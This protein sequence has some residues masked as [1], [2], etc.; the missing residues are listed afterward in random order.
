MLGIHKTPEGPKAGK[1]GIKVDQKHKKM[2]RRGHKRGQLFESK[3]L[4]S[5]VAWQ[6]LPLITAVCH[7][8]LQIPVP[9]Y[10]LCYLAL[11]SVFMYL[12]GA[13]VIP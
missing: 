1:G 11:P 13:R 5:T 9:N 8:I 7:V 10:L 2:E 3:L 4:I 12:C 6:T